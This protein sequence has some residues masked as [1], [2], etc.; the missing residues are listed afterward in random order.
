[1][2]PVFEWDF[3]GPVAD[4]NPAKEF[5]DVQM[6]DS[7]SEELKASFALDFVDG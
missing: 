4:A 7:A 3:R 1:M 6:R 2:L 5:L